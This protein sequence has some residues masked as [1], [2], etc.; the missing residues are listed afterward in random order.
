MK[1]IPVRKSPKIYIPI[2]AKNANTKKIVAIP[3]DKPVIT[4]N[5]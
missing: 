1:S 4:N 2:K 3:A 5:F